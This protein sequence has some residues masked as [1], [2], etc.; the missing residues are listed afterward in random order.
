MGALTITYTILGV[1]HNDD[2]IM[3][4]KNPILIIEAPTLPGQQFARTFADRSSKPA[5]PVNPFPSNLS[6]ISESLE[7]IY[8]ARPRHAKTSRPDKP[9]T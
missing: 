4:P 9:K 6:A 3:G 8:S 2:S 7:Q 1:P 5:S